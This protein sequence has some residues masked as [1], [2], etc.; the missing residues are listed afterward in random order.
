MPV[1]R[2]DSAMGGMMAL[3]AAVRQPTLIKGLALLATPWD[4][5]SDDIQSFAMDPAVARWL[6]DWL[7]KQ[8][9]IS[10]QLVHQWLYLRDPWLVHAQY[11]Y[12]ARLE[13]DSP[14]ATAFIERQHWLHDSVDLTRAVAKDCFIH[15]AIYNLPHLGQWDVDGTVIDPASISVPTFIAT[16]QHDRL[17]PAQWPSPRSV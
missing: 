8:P 13:Q 16:A 11:R 12:F 6:S 15:R 1:L 9:S 4:F 14:E 2:E 3:A 10:G 5:H 7:D 17:V